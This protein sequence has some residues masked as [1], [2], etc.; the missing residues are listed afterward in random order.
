[1]SAWI[2][3]GQ[4]IF[5]NEE[6]AKYTCAYPDRIFGLVAVNLHDPVQAAKELEHYVRLSVRVVEGCV[7]AMES[8][9]F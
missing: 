6:V 7:M 4:M 5:S 8:P 2:R 3:P 1:M 9:A